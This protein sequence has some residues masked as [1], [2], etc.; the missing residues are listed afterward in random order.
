M[1]ELGTEN[2]V[3]SLI[4]NNL[5]ASDKEL[6]KKSGLSRGTFYKYKKILQRKG[7]I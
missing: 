5:G 6:L 7:L 2:F 4:K 3:L 1:G